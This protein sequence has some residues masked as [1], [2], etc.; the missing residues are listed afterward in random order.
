MALCIPCKNCGKFEAS[1]PNVP[2]PANQIEPVI[3]DICYCFEP[4]EQI[5]SSEMNR[6]GQVL[7]FEQ[8]SVSRK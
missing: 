6:L 7:A 5:D 1:H 3:D 4:A 8:R 2:H